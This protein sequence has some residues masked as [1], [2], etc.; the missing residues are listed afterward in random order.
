[1]QSRAK[2]FVY[3]ALVSLAIWALIF[4]VVTAEVT[5]NKPLMVLVNDSGDVVATSSTSIEKAMEKASALPNGVYTLKR[6]DATIEVTGAV[7]TE[8]TI[9]WTAPTQNTD[10]SP[11][12]DLVNYK[13]YYGLTSSSM[14]GV[15]VDT[16][17]SKKINGLKPNTYYFAVSA[18]NSIGAESELSDVVSKVVM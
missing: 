10:D 14:T 1:M 11:L 13:L 3:V 2:S 4:T 16:A 9:S 5:I 15:L 7:S 6:P 12:T 8:V 18:V 17:T